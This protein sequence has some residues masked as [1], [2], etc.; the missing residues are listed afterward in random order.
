M[1]SLAKLLVQAMLATGNSAGCILQEVDHYSRS[2]VRHV[3]AALDWI[4]ET[5]MAF[6]VLR[7]LHQAQQLPNVLSGTTTRVSFG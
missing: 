3:V 7:A 5:R 1:T 4:S 2:A 6:G